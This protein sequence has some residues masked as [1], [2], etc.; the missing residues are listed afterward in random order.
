MMTNEQDSGV[1][2]VHG[3]LPERGDS[4]FYSVLSVS[5][6]TRQLTSFSG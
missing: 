1:D 6:S 3:C 2:I 5:V 4:L